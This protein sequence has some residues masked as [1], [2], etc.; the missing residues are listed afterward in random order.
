MAG[1]VFLLRPIY[2]AINKIQ[3][4][5]ESR[6][7]S[8]AISSVSKVVR[9]LEEDLIVGRTKGEIRLLQPDKLLDR[10][11]GEY[12]KQAS[13]RTYT[14]RTNDGVKHLVS[15]FL[16]LAQRSGIRMALTGSS[17]VSH[18]AVMAR[19]EMV[20]IYCTDIA[21]LM[22]SPQDKGFLQET[23]RFA[24]VE[25]LETTD[26]LLYFDTREDRGIPWASPI[27]TYVELMAGDKRDR[28]T[29]AQVRKTVLQQ[30]A[31]SRA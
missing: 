14:G 9:R 26:D 2:D 12:Q 27:Q 16:A 31:I 5:V 6:G 21:S 3:K 23:D 28:E 18:Y 22:N 7:G 19:E 17:S 10:I 13:R 15:K 8:L 4:E 11:A 25:L 30:A 20:S 1:R 24:N 29:A